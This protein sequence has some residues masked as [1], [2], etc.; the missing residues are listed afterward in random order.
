MEMLLSKWEDD[1]LLMHI[2]GRILT[3]RKGIIGDE[4]H[5]LYSCPRREYTSGPS[6]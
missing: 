5:T 1:P 4:N 3:V 6:E 2:N